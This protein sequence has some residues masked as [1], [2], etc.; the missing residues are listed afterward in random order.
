M[1]GLAE[2][3]NE[4]KPVKTFPYITCLFVFLCIVWWALQ[5][6]V[7]VSKT[8]SN[9][10]FASII[11][12][13]VAFIFATIVFFSIGSYKQGD[14]NQLPFANEALKVS[15]IFVI[16]VIGV[17]L[18]PSDG[19]PKYSGNLKFNG[20]L[21]RSEKGLESDWTDVTPRQKMIKDLLRNRLPDKS[22]DEIFKL[23]GP[24]DTEKFSKKADLA[25]L[26]GVQRSFGID[27]EWLLIYFQDDKA[28]KAEI[29]VD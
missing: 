7:V 2:L 15:V 5:D 24:S 8:V 6:F 9:V 11:I 26:L 28:L 20:D 21:W 17:I 4:D 13:G 3:I 1:E 25:Y 22:K 14:A 19:L 23:L 16:F 12:L 29:Y 10:S 18:L 27:N